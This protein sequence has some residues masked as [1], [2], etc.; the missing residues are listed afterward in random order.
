MRMCCRKNK[1]RVP[2]NFSLY[3]QTHSIEA[4]R[5]LE[6]EQEQKLE[7]KL[8]PEQEQSWRWGLGRE[9]QAGPW[10]G[11]RWCPAVWRERCQLWYILIWNI[12]H[13]RVSSVFTAECPS[14][15]CANSPPAQSRWTQ[16]DLLHQSGKATWADPSLPCERS[17]LLLWHLDSWFKKRNPQ[18]KQLQCNWRKLKRCFNVTAFVK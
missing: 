8:K 18:S 16:A 13:W 6:L 14:E 10:P 5:E 11:C 17:A 15:N 7:L 12:S 1:D 3:E 2:G 9:L 4:Y